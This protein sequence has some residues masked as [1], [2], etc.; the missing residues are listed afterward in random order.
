MKIEVEDV[1]PAVIS[2][3]LYRI[4]DDIRAFCIDIA[5]WRGQT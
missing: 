4:L 3:E 1:R 2:D 5:Y